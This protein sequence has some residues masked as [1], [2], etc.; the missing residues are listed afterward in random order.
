MAIVTKRGS[1]K[2]ATPPSA[3][4]A[5]YKPKSGMSSSTRRV[6]IPKGKRRGK[7]K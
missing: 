6:R 5:S 2:K 4:K 7:G 3:S 1:V